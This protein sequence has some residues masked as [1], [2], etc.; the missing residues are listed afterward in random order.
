MELCHCQPV[1][2]V[3]SCKIRPGISLIRPFFLAPD[4][5]ISSLQHDLNL[6][7]ICNALA[8]LRRRRGLYFFRR[9]LKYALPLYWWREGLF[10]FGGGGW[11]LPCRY[12]LPFT[13]ICLTH[14]KDHNIC[15]FVNKIKDHNW[16][17]GKPRASEDNLIFIDELQLAYWG[18]G[19]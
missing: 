13:A 6:Q 12:I 18:R 3:C 5:N 7:A 2:T 14:Q 16:F 4:H 9:M 11:R 1:I 15:S 8:I 17:Q 10:F 19:H